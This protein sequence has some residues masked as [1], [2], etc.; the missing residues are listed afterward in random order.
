MVKPAAL[1]RSSVHRYLILII[2]LALT[3]RVLLALALG[4]ELREVSGTFDQIAYDLLGQR[5]SAG[6][7]FSFPTTWYPFA[8]A[9]EPTAHWS[10]LYTLY[11]AAIYSIFGHHPL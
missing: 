6:Y 1:P 4:E 2:L 7:G 5:V 11:L 10:F 9:N 3:L 8:R